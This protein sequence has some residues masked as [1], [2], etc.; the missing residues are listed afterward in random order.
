VRVPYP[1]FTLESAEA[2][3]AVVAVPGDLFPHLA[4]LPV[5]PA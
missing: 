3:F 2:R 4:P 5:L 1:D